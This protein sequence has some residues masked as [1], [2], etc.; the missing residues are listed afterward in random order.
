MS[1]L[2]AKLGEKNGPT[3]PSQL[4]VLVIEDSID[5]YELIVDKIKREGFIITPSRVE[6]T[7]ELSHTLVSKH[8]DLVISDNGLP[9]F[10]ARIA[11]SIT[12]ESHPNV[13][14]IIVSG[15][16]GEEDAIEALLAGAN[17]YIL[18]DNLTRLIPSIHRELREYKQRMDRISMEHKLR[19]SQ[20][21]YQL[22]AENVQDLVCVHDT[23]GDYLWVSPSASKILGFSA[24]ELIELGSLT[25]IHPDDLNEVTNVFESLKKN[26]GLHSMQRFHYRRKR[27]DGI[28]IYLETL[29][30]PVY[31]NDWLTRIVTTTRDITEQMLATQL[32]EENQ[33]RYEGVLESLSE[34]VILLNAD[35]NIVT[36]NKS[37]RKI[38]RIP[39][40]D[41]VKLVDFLQENFQLLKK[42]GKTLAP[43]EFPSNV[44][45]RTG[46]SKYNMLVGLEK[47]GEVLWLSVNSVSYNLSTSKGVVLSFTDVTEQNNSQEKIQR[48][49]KE[50]VNLIENANAPI[51]G[52][53]WNGNITEWNNYT[54]KITG[55]TKE[56]VLGK[57]LLDTFILKS[58]RDHIRTLFKEILRGVNT[59][60]YEVPIITKSGRIVTILLNGTPRRDYE[61]NIV[62]MVAVGQDITELIEYRD[63]LEMKVEERTLELKK[64]L[65]KEKE[66]V[67]LKSKFVSMASHEF[68]TPLSTIKFASDF[69]KKYHDQADWE[70][71]RIKLFKIDEQVKHM[72]HLL[73]DVLVI[74]K[75]QAGMIKVNTTVIDLPEF[76]QKIIE[77]VTYNSG[78]THKVLDTITL[79]VEQV[80]A[81]EKLLRNILINLLSNAIK[82]SPGQDKVRLDVLCRRNILSISVQ[83]WGLGIEKTE[84]DKVFE[85]FHRSDNVRDIQ[86]T[87]LGLSIVKKAV[88]IQNGNIAFESEPGKGT[89]FN[90][91]LPTVYHNEKENISS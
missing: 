53:D 10:N 45:L 4:K 88:E 61:G 51:F 9:G 6:T 20:R 17:D 89:T 73:D 11:L 68:R 43:R 63:T 78:F 30:E 65:A 67:S 14:F 34:G 33:A 90:V 21:N 48:M 76:F 27:K 86:G 50:L 70:K 69:I 24:E 19:K 87:G 54:R 35:G 37:A 18:K 13:P 29:A 57:S 5:D 42:N 82:F 62:G 15:S 23:D 22:L 8:W 58:H 64:A 81:D 26:D 39:G 38:L 80:I 47:H 52:I 84:H 40:K 25:N 7:E 79:E 28:Y 71:L 2:K 77:E 1:R 49:A 36:H 91:S 46:N 16:L 31:E 32:L 60:N 74:G 41:C 56:E 83:D 72:T 85:A 59:T 75:S 44:T 3:S 12:R 55:F 66:L